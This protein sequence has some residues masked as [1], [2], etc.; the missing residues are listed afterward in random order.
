MHGACALH[1]PVHHRAPAAYQAAAVNSS[2][3]YQ[4]ASTA[5]MDAVDDAATDADPAAATDDAA[6]D[7]GGGADGAHGSLSAGL[8]SGLPSANAPPVSHSAAAASRVAAPRA[9]RA[10]AGDGPHARAA[11]GV[12]HSSANRSLREVP[13]AAHIRA[14]GGRTDMTSDVRGGMVRSMSAE[15][16]RPGSA[17]ARSAGQ[18]HLSRR[19]SSATSVHTSPPMSRANSSRVVAGGATER[20]PASVASAEKGLMEVAFEVGSALKIQH[21]MFLPS[22]GPATILESL[23]KLQAR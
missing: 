3:G 15:A 11:N 18:P 21:G 13:S 2:A 10:G 1:T 22:E 7:G 5:A 17:R 14:S 23:L 4:A 20:A 19:G 9:V 8:P 16:I 12:T 6:T